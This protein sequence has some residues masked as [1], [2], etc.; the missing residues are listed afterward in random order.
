MKSDERKLVA[1]APPGVVEKVI[2]APCIGFPLTSDADAEL[3]TASDDDVV[4][5][6]VG[7]LTSICGFSFFIFGTFGSVIVNW[8]D[9]LFAKTKQQINRATTASLFFMTPPIFLMWVS[10]RQNIEAAHHLTIVLCLFD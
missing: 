8:A 3:E 4:D 5:V 7:E 6:D 1:G 2:F 9:A 10:Y